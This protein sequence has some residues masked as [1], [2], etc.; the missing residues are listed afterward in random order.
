MKS[1]QT[2]GISIN[3]TYF[4]LS[5]LHA[6]IVDNSYTFLKKITA[7]VSFLTLEITNLCLAL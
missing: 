3:L 6:V 7:Y 2:Q 1:D 4:P 5:I